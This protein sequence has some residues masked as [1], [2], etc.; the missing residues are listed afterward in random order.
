MWLHI[1][2]A[3]L[4]SWMW[5]TA[6]TGMLLSMVSLDREIIIDRTWS[7]V[8]GSISLFSVVIIFQN[9]E[10]RMNDRKE[11]RNKEAG[12]YFWRHR[13][14]WLW[15]MPFGGQFIGF[16]TIFPRHIL[17]SLI[18]YHILCQS[19]VKS[20]VLRYSLA[21]FIGWKK[22]AAFL[23][24]VPVR[25][26]YSGYL[27]G[28]YIITRSLYWAF[29]SAKFA[30]YPSPKNF[31]ESCST[32]QNFSGSYF[33]PGGFCLFFGYFPAVIRCLVTVIVRLSTACCFCLDCNSIFLDY[34]LLLDFIFRILD[35]SGLLDYQH[36][37]ASMSHIMCLDISFL[38][39]HRSVYGSQ[40]WAS[41]VIY[42]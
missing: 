30:E 3:K 12:Y 35:F 15:P 27:S 1:H 34:S 39:S 24:V 6:P 25:S 16:S 33:L 11:E 42:H 21:S 17:V 28:W 13:A 9:I 40:R 31:G 36:I 14:P 7:T 41:L 4:V 2:S 8:L 38:V 32:L 20:F 10:M 19:L 5:I 26:R 23:L 37:F 22:H 29:T 18:W